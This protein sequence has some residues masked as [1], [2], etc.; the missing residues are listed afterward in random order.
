MEAIEKEESASPY[1][2]WNERITAECY[3][4]NARSRIMNERGKI[5]QISNNYEKISF[6]FGPTLLSWMDEKAGITL[7]GIQQADRQSQKTR[8]GF[9][10]ALAQPYNHIILPLAKDKDLLTQIRW[11]K[12][13]F[14]KRFIREPEGMWLPETAVDLRT[15]MA[16]QQEGIRFTILA[17]HQAKRFR[18]SGQKQ[19]IETQGNI[20][21]RRPYWC[22]LPNGQKIALFFYTG[23]L[24]HAIAF[25][26]LLQNG[27]ALFQRLMS[28]FDLQEAGPQLVHVATDGESYGHHHPFGDMAL[29]YA[30]HLLQQDPT[31]QLT[32]YGWFLAHYP[33]QFEVEINENTSWSCSHGLERWRSDCSCRIG[34]P[35]QQQAWRAPLREGLNHLKDE[36]DL[37]FEHQGALLLKDPWQARD[38]YIQVLLDPSQE[39]LDRFFIDQ[40]KE[41]PLSQEER[42]AALKLLEM[43]RHGMLMFTSCGWFFDEISGLETTQILKYACRS[44]QLAKDSGRDLEEPLLTYLRKAPSNLKEYGNGEKIWEV[45]IRPFFVDL[46]RVIAHTA[47]GSIFQK[48]QKDRVYCYGLNDQDQV[49]LPQNGSH[50][51]IGRFKVTSTIT[52]E[53]KEMVFSVLHFGGVD[54]QCLLKPYQTLED[55]ETIKQ[56]ILNLYKTAS[57]G[58]VY[59]WLKENFGP[60][61][62]D[63]KDLFLEERQKLIEFLLQDRLESRL[64]LLGE[65]IKEDTRTLIKLIDMGVVLPKPIT[66]VLTLILDQALQQGIE[67]AFSP[68]QRLEGLEEFFR[69]SL[70]LGDPL[71]KEQI[72]Q[73]IQRKIK[74]SINQLKEYPD[75]GSHFKAISKVIQTC[76][77]F[78]VPLN[79]WNLQNSFLDACRDLPQDRTEFRERYQAFA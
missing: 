50:L 43:Q 26:N 31:I 76:N 66:T 16:L 61:R 35:E 10:N 73:R 36:L 77:H 54:F 62:F 64:R 71:T 28:G 4:P 75:P 5:A 24:S 65:W 15:L 6:N 34:G 58:D 12:A 47:I 23:G 7:K 19:W 27:E 74:L 3:A 46:S 20:N 56:K 60:R 70:E 1:H 78:D 55:Y 72:R 30:L 45:K 48:N 53:E 59:D 52:Q 37:L 51:A 44:I 14:I 49:I 57:L 40:R 11:A 2:D 68:A 39:T 18:P 63:L 32:N 17:P 67:E 9:G 79:L 8:Q 42:V 29:A 69:R 38:D 21:S 13:E 22:R 41:H 33:P 25:E